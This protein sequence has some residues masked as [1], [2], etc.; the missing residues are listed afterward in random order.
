MNLFRMTNLYILFQSLAEYTKRDARYEVD[1][2]LEQYFYHQN[3]A[4]FLA[5]RFAQR[6][7]ISNPSPSHI[8]EIATAF[9]TGNYNGFGSNKYG[10]LKATVAAVILDREAQDSSLDLDPTQ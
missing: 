8:K 9:R 10:C 6:F 4:P 7:G 5:V 1:A 2:A 3:T